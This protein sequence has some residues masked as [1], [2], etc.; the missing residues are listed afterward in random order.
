MSIFLEPLQQRLATLPVPRDTKLY[1]PFILSLSELEQ[2]ETLPE[3]RVSELLLEWANGPERG[4]PFHSFYA[5]RTKGQPIS[6]EHVAR[7]ADQDIDDGTT[8]LFGTPV[9]QPQV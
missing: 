2:L 9:R 8:T 1:G 7:L 5:R 3:K 4:W 6:N